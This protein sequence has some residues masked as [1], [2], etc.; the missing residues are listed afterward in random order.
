MTVS[1]LGDTAVV[2]T[3][4]GE[5]DAAMA[6][7]VAAVAD[8]LRREL[9]QEVVD[10]VPAFRS[11]TV[12][13]GQGHTSSL[14]VLRTS[15]R[16]IAQGAG[17]SAASAGRQV[18]VPVCY[19]SAM[20]PDLAE[21][22]A[23]NGLSAADVVAL[24]SG[25]DYLVHAI[26]FA[27]GFPYLGGLPPALATPRRSTPRPLV[28]AGAVGIG[29]TQTGVYPFATPGGWNL[30]GR[31]PV[32][33]FDVT[34][35]TP[36]LLAAGDRVRFRPISEREFA[37]ALPAPP[38]SR[39]PSPPPARRLTVIRP[40]LFTSIQDLGRPGRRH[41]GV[42]AGGAVDAFSLRLLNLLVGN[43]EAAAGLEF[44]LV[45]PTVR[46]ECDAVV[47]VGG[48]HSAALPRWQPCRVTAGTTVDFGP[49][50][51]GCRG[52]LAVAGGLDVPVVLG[53]RGLHQR[54]GLGGGFGRPLAAG[55]HVGFG[56]SEGGLTLGRWRLD[57]RIL[58]SREDPCV[59]RVLPDADG[60]AYHAAA[61]AALYQVSAKSDRM[62]LRLSGPIL[63]D[64][65]KGERKSSAVLPG[66]IQVPPDGQPI[67]LLADAQTIGGY[68]RLGNVITADLPKAAQLRPGA[69]VRFQPVALDEAN[70]ARAARER[71]LGLVR[72]G[73]ANKR[74]RV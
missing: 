46:F 51:E 1:P 37:A 63:A 69:R 36:A 10:V 22:A 53:G 57:D 26:G 39:E 59:L 2:L 44:T 35:S 23:A 68:P 73:V 27:P 30:I 45:G 29:G 15:V 72:Q 65:T 55:D 3:L 6:G 24:H 62:G 70:V 47:A 25:G 52:Y 50:S 8:A 67:V 21:V 64:E 48:A 9:P 74:V 19:E 40:G 71:V 28:P 12:V 14:D 20:A 18:E 32:S 58:P 16:S 42:T 11:V 60:A 31:T 38:A 43:D 7:R 41:E 56:E 54:A 13:L 61:W 66:T 33:L 34:R 17:V 49:L 4:A 5:I